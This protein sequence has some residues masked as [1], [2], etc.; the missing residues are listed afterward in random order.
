MRT[1]LIAVALAAGCL[2]APQLG[3]AQDV[4]SFGAVAPAVD[5]PA[6][7]SPDSAI[8]AMRMQLRALVAAQEGH[9][10]EHGSF[11]TDVSALGMHVRGTERR[12]KPAVSVIFAGGRSWSAIAT[13]GALPEKTCAIFV[14]EP[15]NLPRLPA[16]LDKRRKPEQQGV[17]V[18][19]KR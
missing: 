2:F 11:T 16:T 15:E 12:V 14:G 8:R 7:V 5:D 19:D 6:P 1:S 9:W 18:C 3:A 4:Y 17:P 13:H 10:L